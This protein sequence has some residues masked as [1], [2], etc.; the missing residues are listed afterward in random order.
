[1]EV[2]LDS[3]KAT[4]AFTRPYPFE[5]AVL[6]KELGEAGFSQSAERQLVVRAR[7][8]SQ[9]VATVWTQESTNILYEPKRAFLGAESQLAEGLQKGFGALVDLAQKLFGEEFESELK[10]SELV[11]SARS[12][13]GASV[14]G[15]MRKMP[16]AP[17][18]E[19]VKKTLGLDFAPYLVALYASD[20]PV[21]DVPFYEVPVWSHLRLE[22]LV[23]N[24]RYLV[25][26]YVYRN[27]NVG[28]VQEQVKGLLPNLKEIATAAVGEGE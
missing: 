23:A 6:D 20:P 12:L 15:H 27:P 28:L 13:A 16:Q 7:D 21:P 18:A 24:P 19:K 14:V 11:V 4:L 5:D 22:P 26:R 9:E 2:L 10:W 3:A 8:S 25:I 1:M 17:L